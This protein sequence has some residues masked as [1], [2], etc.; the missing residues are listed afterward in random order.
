MLY[1]DPPYNRRAYERYYHLPNTLIAGKALPVSGRSGIPVG[2]TSLS[3]FYYRNS[4]S[5]ALRDLTAVASAKSILLHYSANGLIP[6]RTILQLLKARGE[7]HWTNWTVRR[8]STNCNQTGA[9]AEH[10][11]YWCRTKSRVY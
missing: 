11:L 4:A 2:V 6:H 9:Y 5:D 10:R 3:P 1:L 7:T 8:Y